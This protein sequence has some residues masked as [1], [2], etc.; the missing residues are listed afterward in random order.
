MYSS[1]ERLCF[2]SFPVFKISKSSLRHY[3]KKE[4]KKNPLIWASLSVP[5]PQMKTN[6]QDPPP[7]LWKYHSF[8]FCLNLNVVN[9]NLTSK[10]LDFADTV[11][12]NRKFFY[13]CF[14]TIPS[15]L[16]LKVNGRLVG[17]NFYY[18]KAVILF[19]L[20]LKMRDFLLHIQSM[21]REP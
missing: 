18:C 3:D 21:L 16:E 9:I 11:S 12:P 8:P 4:G 5:S 14:L 15:S 17:L 19:S 10:V 6:N 7:P 1:R 20:S 13:W 2:F